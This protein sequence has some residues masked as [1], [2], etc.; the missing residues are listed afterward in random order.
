VHCEFVAVLHVSWLVQ[1]GTGVHDVHL[2][3]GPLSSRN[4]PFTHC[5]HCEFDAVVQV[6]MVVQLSTS[7]HCTH[8][9]FALRK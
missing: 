8:A 5:V 7:V 9:P 3:A 2:S 1:N 4:V 6:S